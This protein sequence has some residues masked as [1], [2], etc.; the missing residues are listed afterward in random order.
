M[1]FKTKVGVSWGKN[2]IERAGSEL[3]DAER[4][5]SIVGLYHPLTKHVNLVAEYNHLDVEAATGTDYKG[6]AKTGSLGAILFF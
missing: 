3:R 4:E 1:P 6:K 2:I 5:A